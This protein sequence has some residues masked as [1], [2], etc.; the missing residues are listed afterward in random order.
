MM[1]QLLC[2][3]A[4]PAGAIEFADRL[5]GRHPLRPGARAMLVLAI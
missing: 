2:D 4:R 1:I 3:V 5:V